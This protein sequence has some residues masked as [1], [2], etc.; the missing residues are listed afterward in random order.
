VPSN[1]TFA[2]LSIGVFKM[3]SVREFLSA[4]I[5]TGVTT[6]IIFRVDFLREVT[7]GISVAGPDGK[8]PANKKPL[9]M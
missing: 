8:P 9:Y 6:A 1:G 7:T 5:M 4:L 3:P 2:A